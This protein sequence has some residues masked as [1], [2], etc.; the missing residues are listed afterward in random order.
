[1]A[2]LENSIA[3][4]SSLRVVWN[5]INTSFK[6]LLWFKK[7]NLFYYIYSLIKIVSNNNSTVETVKKKPDRGIF[8]KFVVNKSGKPCWKKRKL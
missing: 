4:N 7:L 1:M 8:L 6:K 5:F 3:S 2:L